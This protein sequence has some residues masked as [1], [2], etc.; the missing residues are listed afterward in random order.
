VP[1][2]LPFR[3][4][5]DGC[6]D[7]LAAAETLAAGVAAGGPFPAGVRVVKD[8][9][10]RVTAAVTLPG[11][12]GPVAAFVK[13]RRL[14]SARERLRAGHR[15]RGAAEA[16]VLAGLASAGVAVPDVFGWSVR[17]DLGWDVLVLAAVADGVDL[18]ARLA[19][20][21]TSRARRAVAAE[22]GAL[23][24]RAHD[25]GWPTRTSTAATCS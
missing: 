17:P 19:A 24:R 20:G 25:A 22:I 5:R 10:M 23:L 13:V 11:P 7:A 18:G 14:R 8:R 2:P 4:S 9:P 15:P 1:A 21:I 12:R 16:H 3:W 6:A